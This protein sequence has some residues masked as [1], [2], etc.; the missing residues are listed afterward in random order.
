MRLDTKDITAT[1][2][3]LCEMQRH[4]CCLLLNPK[5]SVSVY[6]RV[7]SQVPDHR[8]SS[9]GNTI[10]RMLDELQQLIIIELTT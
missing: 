8:I 10:S 7:R 4:T 1:H 3:V 6:T 9:I 5:I 2:F